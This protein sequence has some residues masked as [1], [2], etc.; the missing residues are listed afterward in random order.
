MRLYADRNRGEDPVLPISQ[1]SV[2]I[3]KITGENLASKYGFKSSSLAFCSHFRDITGKSDPFFKFGF[4]NPS[5]SAT[6]IS[7]GVLYYI[8]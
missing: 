2:E 5:G 8:L 4:V 3:L 7:K 1:F 6:T